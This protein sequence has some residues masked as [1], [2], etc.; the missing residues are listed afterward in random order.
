MPHSPPELPEKAVSGG[1]E[2]ARLLGRWGEQLVAEDLRHRGRR[3]VAMNYR[4]RMGEIDIIAADRRYLIFVEVKLRKSAGFG[5]A[6]EA[7]TRTKQ[8]KLR[9]AAELYLSE[10][11]TALQPRFDVAEV[12]AP[13]GIRTAAPVISYIENAF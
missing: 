12:Y 11:P 7:V 8:E 4:C 6:A 10:H 3:I 5:R 2:A 13:D 9:A 1:G